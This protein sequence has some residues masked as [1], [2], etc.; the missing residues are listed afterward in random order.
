MHCLNR[1]DET[2]PTGSGS[3]GEMTNTSDCTEGSDSFVIQNH[4]ENKPMLLASAPM[5]ASYPR[6]VC[7]ASLAVHT[8]CSRATP[9]RA[10]VESSP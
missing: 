2:R 7:S 1:S 4:L 8:A 10:S 3:L 5:S 9:C 6:R